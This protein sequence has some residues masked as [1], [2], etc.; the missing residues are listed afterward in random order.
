MANV[1]GQLIEL[2]RSGKVRILAVTTPTRLVGA[3][4]IPTAVEQGL[5]AM[6]SQNFI[7]LFAP[8]GTPRPIVEQI[9][10]ATRAAIGDAEYRRMLLASGLEPVLAAGPDKA[11]SFVAEELAR[12]T[13]LIKAVGLKID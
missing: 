5:P 12:L 7:G 4:D 8:A 11:R 3:P 10:R 1:T 9:S 13:P 2:N 6:I